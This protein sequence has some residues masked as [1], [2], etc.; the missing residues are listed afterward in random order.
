MTHGKNN[1]FADNIHTVF[2]MA[3]VFKYQY[4]SSGHGCGWFSL[5][6]SISYIFKDINQ[7]APPPINAPN[8]APMLMVAIIGIAESNQQK[9]AI[10]SAPQI[11]HPQPEEHPS[12][13]YPNIPNII[14][15]IPTVYQGLPPTKTAGRKENPIPP[16]IPTNT[17]LIIVKQIILPFFSSYLIRSAVLSSVR[18]AISSPII[19]T[20]HK[21]IVINEAYCNILPP[22]A[23]PFLATTLQVHV[24]SLRLQIYVAHIV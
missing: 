22:V 18:I 4:I 24:F 12:I 15:G 17:M 8:T 2:L 9:K 19:V 7:P 10:P 20:I 16:I 23:L 13:L 1:G 3:L 14:A 21:N 6:A 11:N 5:P